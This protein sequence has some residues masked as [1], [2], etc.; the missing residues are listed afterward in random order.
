M[1]KELDRIAKA[2]QRTRSELLREAFRSYFR[3]RYGEVPATAAELRALARG[4]AAM[5][6]GDYLTLDELRHAVE[7]PRRKKRHPKA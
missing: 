3:L 2:E 7:S 1:L 4:R 5:K 6:R